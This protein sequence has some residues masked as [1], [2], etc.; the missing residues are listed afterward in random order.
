MNFVLNFWPSPLF[1]F[2]WL[3]VEGMWMVFE[4][5]CLSNQDSIGR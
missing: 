1:M 3:G 4:T 2:F 5:F